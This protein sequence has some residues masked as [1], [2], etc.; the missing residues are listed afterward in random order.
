MHAC[1]LTAMFIYM[2]MEFVAGGELYSVIQ[3]GR[4]DNNQARLLGAEILL[5]L[6]FAHSQNVI[7]RDMKPE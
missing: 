6:E 7:Y 5:G 1:V 2:V 4:M 3:R